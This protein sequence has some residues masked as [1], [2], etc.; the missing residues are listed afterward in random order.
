MVSS[1]LD[2]DSWVLN[3]YASIYHMQPEVATP[4]TNLKCAKNRS[5][6]KIFVRNQIQ[7]FFHIIGPKSLIVSVYSNHGS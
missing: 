1:F 5:S 6:Y 3:I 7:F 2:F 4:I